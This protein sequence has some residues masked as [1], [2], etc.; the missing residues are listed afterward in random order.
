MAEEKKSK[1][2]IAV[3]LKNVKKKKNILI[4]NLDY[5]CPVLYDGVA[6]MVP[7]RVRKLAVKDGNKL[8]ILPRGIKLI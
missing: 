4:S 6:M 7:P 2:E 3:V 1:K 5:P 8:G